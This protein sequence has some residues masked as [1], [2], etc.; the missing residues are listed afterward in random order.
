MK[1]TLYFVFAFSL[2]A[3]LATTALAQQING[4]I[5]KVRGDKITIEVSRQEASTVSVGDTATLEISKKAAAVPAAGND[6]LTG[7]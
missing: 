5:T 4:T 1:K 7:C 2:V 3:A 6:M